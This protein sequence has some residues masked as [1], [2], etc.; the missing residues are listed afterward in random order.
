MEV[1]DFR[2]SE[3]V[4][5]P[6]KSLID[7]DHQVTVTRLDRRACSQIAITRG[8]IAMRIYRQEILL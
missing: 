2:S 7:S 3:N 6:R 8:F 5:T 1:V 4:A